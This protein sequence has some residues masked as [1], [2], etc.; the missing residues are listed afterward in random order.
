MYQQFINF[1]NCVRN[2]KIIKTLMIFFIL[3]FT[4]GIFFQN[5]FNIA[6][7][8]FFN[9]FQKD[10]ESLVLGKIINDKYSISNTN[11]GLGFAY[12]D[13]N[14]TYGPNTLD[15]YVILKDNIEAKKFNVYQS[16]VGLQGFIYSFIFNNLNIN[17]IKALTLATS[18]A[19]AIT[20]FLL[21][22]LLWIIIGKEFAIIFYLSMIL[23]PWIVS[24][25]SNLY[26]VSFTWFLPAIFS[27][28][29]FVD[30]D[31]KRKYIWLFCFMLSIFI[32]SL[33]GYEYL[34]TI[35][36]FALSVFFIAPFLEN[37]SISKN[38]LLKYIV[39]IFG[40]S[41]FGFLLAIGI[42]SLLRGE[43]DLLLG[44]KNIYEQDVLRRTF[45]GDVTKFDPVY[46][47][48]FNA[49]LLDVLKKYI[50]EF[51]TD[52]LKGISGK[53]FPVLIILNIIILFK[54]KSFN[55]K[56]LNS[57]MFIVFSLAPL[58]WYFL[59]KSHSFIH[60]HMNYVLWYFGFIAV[61][62]YIP[63]QYFYNLFLNCIEDKDVNTNSKP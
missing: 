57:A 3:S 18:I 1:K 51:N 29:V 60:T 16:Q 41:I 23:S 53:F 4:I 46:S 27:F 40:L 48:S 5:N 19:M 61:L 43:G 13:E 31:N 22:Y 37:N 21:S 12:I 56:K 6:K 47:N 26:W 58:S 42:H 52:L 8:D 11:Y 32:K 44:L 30:I 14:G 36:L 38:K 39:I 33:C 62:I 35:V 10:S 50:F 45:G 28:L 63:I 15:S 9:S 34:S 54:T 24:F 55:I 25:S 7:S 2:N 20:I 59:G 49:S 17:K